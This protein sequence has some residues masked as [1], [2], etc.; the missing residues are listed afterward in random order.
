M[1]E[2]GATFVHFHFCPLLHAQGATL[3]QAAT[4]AAQVAI[5]QVASFTAPVNSTT[6]AASVIVLLV[7]LL[8]PLLY[9]H[10]PKLSLPASACPLSAFDQ[11]APFPSTLSHN[12]FLSKIFSNMLFVQFFLLLFLVA[13]LWTIDGSLVLFHQFVCFGDKDLE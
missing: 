12:L 6:L 11:A 1:L 13:Y 2:H 8:L 10:H 3:Q 9:A 4:S 5:I 7:L